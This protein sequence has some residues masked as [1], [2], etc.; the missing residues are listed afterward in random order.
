MVYF[1]FVI[2][3]KQIPPE[4]I[5]NS[6][7]TSFED[8]ILERTKGRGVDLVLNSLVGNKLEASTRCL[9]R[10]GR[11][12][13]IG[14]VDLAANK[15]F[16]MHFFL[17]DASYHGIMLDSLWDARPNIRKQLWQMVQDGLDSG[18][19]QP[20]PYRSFTAEHVEPA[21]RHMGH[22]KHI[23][24]VLISIDSSETPA[25]PVVPQV[26]F[27]PTKSYI[28]IGGLGGIGLEFVNWIRKRNAKKIV[29]TS[30]S[31]V[32]TGY[33]AAYIK[34]WR[35]TG[36]EVKVLQLDASDP[37]NAKIVFD[38]AQK[39]G[40]LGGFFNLAM[41]LQIDLIK[42][43]SPESYAYAID[44]KYKL[45][46]NMDR[47]TRKHCPLL[48]HFVIF[49]SIAA[50]SGFHGQSNYG[51][52]NSAAERLIEKRV[53]DG[54]PGKAIQWGP[55]GEAGRWHDEYNADFGRRV[56][57]GNGVQGI[58]S[59]L[60]SLDILLTHPSPVVTS[61]RTVDAEFVSK[62]G[63]GHLGIIDRIA[64]VLGHSADHSLDPNAKLTDLGMDS[65]MSMEVKQILEHE[66]SL[67]LSAME[68]RTLSLKELEDMANST[69]N[70]KL[71]AMRKGERKCPTESL[72][73]I[74]FMKER[75]LV[76]HDECLYP[77]N[78][79]AR[80]IAKLPEGIVETVVVINSAEP[81]ESM[82]DLGAYLN[83]PAYTMQLT[84]EQEMETVEQVARDYLK[85]MP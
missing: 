11:F 31:G 30:R 32:T 47:L 15:P 21:F 14:K 1:S 28:V 68:I 25:L 84:R 38:E 72:F 12:L 18:V 40:P 60:K 2:F 63:K 37:V 59:C 29:L 64:H 51:F 5:A 45:S 80:G 20:L 52:A 56:F 44:P 73:Q 17:R 41:T 10:H 22:G 43:Q 13:E 24:K 78:D 50:G 61:R 83:Y 74:N 19:V 70:N 82:Y 58:S 55:V 3:E 26:H 6:R 85:V 54:Y 4:N 23:G 46:G 48:E 16:G 69:A 39:L 8:M 36:L 67:N 71:E 7:D 53:A 9:A 62:Y 65:V 49:S 77:I 81:P 35:D 57:A 66:F 34:L 42:S 76:F 79:L 33:Q 75:K 27:N